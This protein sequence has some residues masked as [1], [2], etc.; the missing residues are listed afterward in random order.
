ML[1]GAICHPT[2][3]TGTVSIFRVSGGSKEGEVKGAVIAWSKATK[4]GESW[5]AGH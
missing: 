4:K 2:D 1:Q 5:Q 3:D